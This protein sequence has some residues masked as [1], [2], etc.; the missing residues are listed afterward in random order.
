MKFTVSKQDFF[1]VLQKVSNVTPIRST[2][3]IL[4]SILFT[5]KDNTLK[6]RS[7]DLE[8]TMSASC[9]VIMEE[10][11][12]IAIPSKI[13]K[14][15]TS[16]LPDTQLHFHIEDEQVIITTEE[17]GE[18]KIMGHPAMEFPTEPIIDDSKVVTLQAEKFKRIVEKTSFAVSRDEMKVALNGVLFQFFENE[19]RAVSTD[20]H[21]LVKYTLKEFQGAEDIKDIIIPPKFLNLSVSSLKNVD[22]VTL[23]IGSNHV[24]LEL[25]DTTI[26][27]RII[28][29]RF[30]D[31]ESVIPAENNKKIFVKI[32]PLLSAVKRVG[33]FASKNTRQISLSFSHNSA[34]IKAEDIE[35]ASTAK[36]S[37]SLEYKDE[38]FTIGYNSDYLRELIRH[39]DG[40]TVEIN[41][42]NSMMAGLFFPTEQL[43]DEEILFLLMP[44]RLM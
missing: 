14:E 20:G 27:S 22:F 38:D 44:I 8:I 15:I 4:S 1:L 34:L 17:G 23:R 19:L 36:E 16:E 12:A 2:L 11:G 33:I 10:E 6:M 7:T 42:K 32:D 31:Y 9:K 30:P 37:I 18:Y 28:E 39:I 26:Y 29:E 24:M 3:P 40:D 13:I 5:V 41:L 35:T 25:L 21:R 43:P